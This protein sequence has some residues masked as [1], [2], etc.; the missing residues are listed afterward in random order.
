M[1]KIAST[2][3]EKYLYS[4]DGGQN[5]GS[6]FIVESVYT[7]AN[8]AWF[9]GEYSSLIIA[10]ENKLHLTWIDNNFSGYKIK[11]SVFDTQVNS[12]INAIDNQVAVYP[13]PFHDFILIDSQTGD[14]MQVEL[15]DAAGKV[16]LNEAFF[17]NDLLNT[18]SL[19]TGFYLLTLKG[20]NGN[21][22]THLALKQ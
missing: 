19:P 4:T 13:I 16:I 7:P 6:P 18:E 14:Q 15:Q 5:F 8:N 3:Y 9:Y 21:R 12:G 17:A 11:H 22:V 2:L 10:P 20:K 1:L